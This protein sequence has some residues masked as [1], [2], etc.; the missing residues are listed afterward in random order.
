MAI[1][2]YLFF[3]HIV[4]P[5]WVPFSIR[6]AATKKSEKKAVQ[7]P[8][9]AG[10]LLAVMAVGLLTMQPVTARIEHHH[11]YYVVPV[12]A[13]LIAPSSILYLIATL[14][15]FFIVKIRYFKLMGLTLGTAY[16]MSLIFFYHY[17]L[18]VW[19]FFAALV[20]IFMFL[21]LG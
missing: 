12:P 15:P 2:T 11:I 3:V 20:S 21:V 18:S 4:W 19:C 13:W 9:I 17:H 14:V 5:L 16:I 8:I 1:Y 6:Y 7:I 10:I